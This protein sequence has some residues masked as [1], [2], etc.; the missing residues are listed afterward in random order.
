MRNK[1]ILNSHRCPPSVALDSWGN[2]PRQETPLLPELHHVSEFISTLWLS[3]LP[4]QNHIHSHFGFQN[5][6]IMYY[7]KEN[8]LNTYLTYCLMKTHRIPHLKNV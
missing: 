6:R 1:T 4:N 3:N 7:S 5:K 2:C 8:M